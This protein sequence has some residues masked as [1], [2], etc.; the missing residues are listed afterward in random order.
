M[1]SEASSSLGLFYRILAAQFSDHSKR[2][3]I[4]LISRLGGAPNLAVK[5]NTSLD[6]QMM[7]ALNAKERTKQDWMDLFNNADK[8]LNVKGFKQPP[9]S[10]A[11][12]I[13]VMFEE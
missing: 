8:R 13:E 1:D 4:F 3:L 10:P 12:L 5:L 9:G 6:L 2:Q 7:A 11:T